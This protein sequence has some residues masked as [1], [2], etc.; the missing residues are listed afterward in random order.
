MTDQQ[1]PEL[2]ATRPVRSEFARSSGP[3][4]AVRR[5]ITVMVVLALVGGGLYWKF[6]GS[7]HRVPGEIPTI[8]SEGAYK[9][10]PDNPGGIDIPHQDV[11]VYQELDNSSPAQP[12]VEHL[13]PPPE[14]PQAANVIAPRPVP[15]PQAVPQN[16]ETVSAQLAEASVPVPPPAPVAKQV[17]DITGAP[18]PHQPVKT[19]ATQN[20]KPSTVAP[21]AP[22]APVQAAAPASDTPRP[23]TLDQVIQDVTAQSDAQTASAAQASTAAA[24]GPAIQ[25]AS[26]PDQA[27]AQGAMRNLQTKYASI[28]GGVKLRLVK[29]DLAK[30]TYYRVQS[31][32][33]PED[34]AKSLCASLK[35]AN[36]GCIIVRN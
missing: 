26:I 12:Q 17:P 28:L 21:V 34:K 20:R 11:Q 15:A 1:P 31:P 2:F 8:K 22:P 32:P 24:K 13:L 10:R 6:A 25:L 27:A 9:Q 18:P 29:A 19:T 3:S 23:Q 33:L 36:A 4:Y 7:S 30:G 14:A 35:A 5:F 16:V